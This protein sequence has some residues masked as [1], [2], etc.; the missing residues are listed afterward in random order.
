MLTDKQEKF[1]LGILAG[2]TRA[3]AYRA[4]YDCKNSTPKT[5]HDSASKLSRDP[6]VAQW[7]DERKQ[8]AL[9]KLD[10]SQADVLRELWHIATADPNELTQIRRNC[11]R[12]CWGFNFGYQW[13]TEEEWATACARAIQNKAVPPEFDGGDGFDKRLEPNPDCPECEGDGV[14]DIVM[15]DTRKLTGSAR[16]LFAGVKQTKFGVEVMMR[17][18]DGAL[19]KIARHLGLYNDKLHLPGVN[20]AAP[21]IP[22]KA[23]IEGADETT[24]S[25]LYR[26]LMG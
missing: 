9:E 24:V 11:C 7:I 3:D 25:K 17:D 23:T 26:D 10:I 20:G 8:K 1:A 6:V 13:K 2:L 12:H 14:P 15:A 18:Q 16:R 21:T 5:I 4:A 19:D 22:E